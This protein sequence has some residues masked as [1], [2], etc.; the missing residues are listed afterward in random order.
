MKNRYAIIDFETTG[1]SPASGDRITEVAVAV[2]EE[3]KIVDQFQSIVNTGTYISSEITRLTG[4]TNQMTSEAPNA[5]TVI[6]NLIKFVG[7][8]YLV[9]HN[10]SFDG[11]FWNSE[12]SRLGF[13]ERDDF[14]CTL[15]LS[16]RLYQKSPNLKLI[17][18][19]EYHKISFQG[20]AHRALADALVTAELFIKIKYDLKRKFSLSEVDYK[21]LHQIQKESLKNFAKISNEI[22]TELL[23]VTKKSSTPYTKT[24]NLSNKLENSLITNYPVK[25][26]YNTK[27]NV[28]TPEKTYPSPISETQKTFFSAGKIAIGFAVVAL[29][30]D[31]SGFWV[32]AFIAALV[33]FNGQ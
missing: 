27:V 4:I 9:S 2:V 6:P 18:L 14:I 3:D 23:T 21:K 20:N 13:G 17:T 10:A 7:S 11:K 24:A 32:L 1:L 25:E 28:L 16:R 5:S 33:S 19:A 31:F 29:I 22:H 15:L 8:S 12:V 26:I 30:S